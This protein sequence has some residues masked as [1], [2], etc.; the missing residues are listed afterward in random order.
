MLPKTLDFS[1]IGNIL[2]NLV[3]LHIGFFN[4]FHSPNH[5]DFSFQEFHTHGDTYEEAA[6]RGQEVIDT[7]LELYK[8]G[9]KALPFPKNPLLLQ[10]A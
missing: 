3:T 10:V 6:K 5:F 8:E 1:H 4:K 9:G 2:P 7:Y